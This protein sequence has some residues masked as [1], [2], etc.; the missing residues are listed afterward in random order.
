MVRA[1]TDSEKRILREEFLPAILK[2]DESAAER[3]VKKIIFGEDFESRIAAA[4]NFPAASASFVSIAST[5]SIPPL[6]SPL[7]RTFYSTREST[8]RA[9]TL[10]FEDRSFDG[11]S[12]YSKA[13]GASSL[14]EEITISS[15]IPQ[16]MKLLKNNEE[17]EKILDF[18]RS[19]KDFIFLADSVPFFDEKRY[20]SFFGHLE[21]ARSLADSR[22][23]FLEKF[24][25]A[26]DAE[27]IG[28]LATGR[29]FMNDFLA[30][31][32]SKNIL[33]NSLS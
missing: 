14:S 11:R 8:S 22:L 12:T 15:L 3:A 9:S 16:A 32:F 26:S 7:R 23:K 33:S 13:S 21:S 30:A 6:P 24:Y 10:S 28:I 18:F 2:D 31:S 1:L 19:K 20:E 25:S 17:L 29:G 27:L 5:S 4:S